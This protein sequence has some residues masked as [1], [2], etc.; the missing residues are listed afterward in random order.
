MSNVG[1]N[2]ISTSNNMSNNINNI[3]NIG[4]NIRMEQNVAFTAEDAIHMSNA[5][6]QAI[7]ENSHLA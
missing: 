7:A 5:I 6:S 3:N 2:G 4:N 1:N